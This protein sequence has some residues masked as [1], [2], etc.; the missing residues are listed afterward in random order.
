MTSLNL[1]SITLLHTDLLGQSMHCKDL[2][3]LSV[4]RSK[5]L[6][7]TKTKSLY[8]GSDD[9]SSVNQARGTEPRLSGENRVD[10]GNGERP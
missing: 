7:F 5:V 9:G 1:V 4:Q 2:I 6:N 3:L 10:V 8:H